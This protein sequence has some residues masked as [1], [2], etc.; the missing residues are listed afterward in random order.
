MPDGWPLGRK[1]PFHAHFAGFAAEEFAMANNMLE[2]K[3]SHLLVA[4]A[5]VGIGSWLLV[6]VLNGTPLIPPRRGDAAVTVNIAFSAI[7]YV[8]AYLFLQPFL[9]RLLFGW[10]IDAVEARRRRKALEA[11][12]RREEER[13]RW[14]QTVVR[15]SGPVE[16]EDIGSGRNS[17]VVKR[18]QWK[19]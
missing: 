2:R 15:K 7:F 9:E 19:A 1:Y 10:L 17:E 12:Q 16:K 8:V 18:R 14:Y 3:T 5:L 13:E 6:A 4:A 11:A